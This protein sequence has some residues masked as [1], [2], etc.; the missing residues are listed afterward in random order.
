MKKLVQMI[1]MLGLGLSASAAPVNAIKCAVTS[2]AL[3]QVTSAQMA[4]AFGRSQA[5]IEGYLASRQ[6]AVLNKG[7]VCAAQYTTTNL[8]FFGVGMT[9]IYTDRNVYWI[10]IGPGLEM[11]NFADSGATEQGTQTFQNSITEEKGA[12]C[13][14]DLI[15]SDSAADPWMWAELAPALSSL[16]TLTH[17][18]QIPAAATGVTFTVVM[19]GAGPA[20]IQNPPV[21]TSNRLN[22]SI[23]NTQ[24][25]TG[26]HYG[27]CSSNYVMTLAGKPFSTSL[28]VRISCSN[29]P[30]RIYVDKYTL[31]FRQTYKAV[32]NSLLCVAETQNT[33]TVRGF[34]EPN[35]EVYNVT[36]P[37]RPVRITGM[38]HTGVANDYRA[39]FHPPVSNGRYVAVGGGVRQAV[40][41]ITPDNPSALRNPTNTVDFIAV[42]S[43]TLLSAAQGYVDYRA[44]HG[45]M[46]RL[47]DLEDVYDE[48]NYG[49]AD[50]RA[51]RSFFG[52]A[53]RNWSRAPRYVTLVGNGTF[54]YKNFKGANDCV[55]P[56]MAFADENG[57]QSSDIQL[58]TFEA[59]GAPAIAI[60]R[61]P[62]NETN[63]LGR[64][65]AKIQSYESGTSWKTNGVA[66]ADTYDSAAGDFKSDSD[67]LLTHAP[68]RTFQKLYM[69]DLGADTN[70]VKS[71]IVSNLNAGRGIMTYV[72]HASRPY[73]GYDNTST[74]LHMNDAIGLLT[75]ATKP[76]FVLSLS[77]YVNEFGAPSAS[78]LSLGQAL[79]NSTG[80]AAAVWSACG[81]VY[82]ASSAFISGAL[83]SNLYC[84]GQAR[85]G[86]AM[87]FAQQQAIAFQDTNVVSQYNL[88]G[89]PA[90]ASGD[91]NSGR[92]GELAPTGM[93]SYVEWKNWAFP[94]AMVDAGVSDDA[95]ADADGDGVS[96]Y[97]E[98]LAG[99][100]PANVA[101]LLRVTHLNRDSAGRSIVKWPAS[102]HR[103]YAL[104]RSTSINGVYTQVGSDYSAVIPQNVATDAAP[105][106]VTY[107]YRVKAK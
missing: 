67:T 11:G 59:G 82:A 102:S 92:P 64:L 37:T 101:S 50:P 41:A 16:R 57:Q 106:S 80:G 6:L 48:F 97:G 107:F 99:T 87:I 52:Y 81:Y 78:G 34:S 8:T 74:I 68:G 12:Y 63:A 86:D 54:D 46:A 32:S 70:L 2:D 89:D 85:I 31:T 26:L 91:I 83:V 36:D 53:Y 105:G 79:I 61:L 33:I 14:N 47:V 24:I 3:Y 72:G 88:L 98:Y 73:M 58:V 103:K 75:N 29:G 22:F 94:A 84:D 66:V 30:T 45:L 93:P 28:V 21:I 60:G 62:V 25:G 90:M 95:N 23:N 49:I 15:F 96:N 9:N 71:G 42:T 18:S 100:D 19:K 38:L 39:S 77:C 65:V 7:L 69:D 43:T 104:E 44:A 56:T 5:E 51:L 40:F 27:V 4:T 20:P 10:Q 55:V 13:K 76:S 17:T 1:A 35:V